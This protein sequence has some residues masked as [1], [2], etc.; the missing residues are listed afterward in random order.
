MARRP[1][2]HYYTS[3][4]LDVLSTFPFVILG[5]DPLPMHKTLTRK[6]AVNLGF[7]ADK[8]IKAYF[9]FE[10]MSR[11]TPLQPCFNNP[12]FTVDT[13]YMDGSQVAVHKD[14]EERQKASH[15]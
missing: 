11:Y 14:R 6:K 10:G 12:I 3:I 5:L 2:I 15:M 1:F 13:S 8:L 7:S 9:Q 4:Y